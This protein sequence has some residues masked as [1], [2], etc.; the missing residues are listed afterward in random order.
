MSGSG[1]V[2]GPGVVR[3]P[4]ARPRVAVVHGTLRVP[5]TY[6]TLEQA[7]PL[8]DRFEIEFHALATQIAEPL[9]LPV[10]DALGLHRVPFRR[11]EFL[12]P[13]VL[14]RLSRELRRSGPDLLHQQFGTWSSP[15]RHAAAALRAPLLATLHGSDVFTTSYAGRDPRYAWHRR[16]VL[17]VLHEADRVLCV[18]RFLADAAVA[19]G[20]DPGRVEVHHQGVDTDFLTPGEGPDAA[21]GAG[22]PRVLFVGRL[23]AYKGVPDLVE[24]SLDLARRG[25]EH[26]LVL[27][28]DGPLRPVLEEQARRN[29]HLTVAGPRDREG[30][31]DAL[32]GGHV[33]VLPSTP[34]EAAGLVLLEAQA[35]GVPVVAYASG[36]KPEMLEPDRTGSLVPHGDVTA[37]ADAVAG[38]LGLDPAEHAAMAARARE[39]VV[40]QRSMPV[41]AAALG[42][43]YEALLG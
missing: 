35:C 14:G 28:G 26:E 23:A 10:H 6:F 27:V 39:F 40:T 43:H 9:P 13:L 19:A 34:R 38:I 7:L 36:G 29:P 32:R 15:A 16:N 4:G 3:G 21:A 22:P 25:V 12:L 2:S 18:S 1:A 41:S 31:R 24:A 30:V 17:G 5:P 33:L 11:R 37:L 20:A 8:R 42:E